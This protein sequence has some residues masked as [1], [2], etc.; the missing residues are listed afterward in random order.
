MIET[1]AIIAV[2]ISLVICFGMPI[3]AFLFLT[4]RKYR[5]AKPF[6]IGAL[7]FFLTQISTRIPIVTLWLP[8]M[9]WYIRLSLNPYL[10]GLF[11]GLTAGLAEEIGRFVL[12]SLLLKRNRRYVDGIAF[13][14]GHGGIEAILIT[15]LTQ[16][17]LLV[18]MIAIRTG[19]F[20]S[21][22]AASGATAAADAIYQQ[23]TALTPLTL[24]L[25]GAERILAMAMHVGLT[26]I[27]W[28]GL[29]TG[30]KWRS[31]LLAILIHAAIDAAVVILPALLAISTIGLEL[32]FAGCSGLLVLYALRVRRL[33]T[34]PDA[35]TAISDPEAIPGHQTISEHDDP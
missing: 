23:V 12:A 27:I 22:I 25:G 20:E 30:K 10:A 34:Q 3:T 2:I 21:L 26:M 28:A 6:F 1:S 32:V 24:I 13:G 11:L 15:G 17:N 19:Q 8:T 7:T 4:A 31:L 5:I 9:D 35:V 18:L 33:F 29:R 16:I 14:L